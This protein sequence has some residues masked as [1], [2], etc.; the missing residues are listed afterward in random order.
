MTPRE[1]LEILN[2]AAGDGGIR[3]E[4]YDRAYDVLLGAVSEEGIILRFPDVPQVRVVLEY[5]AAQAE[6]E[7]EYWEYERD[8]AKDAERA[9]YAQAVR[10]AYD[11]FW[12][13][14][15]KK[16]HPETL[17]AA[18]QSINTVVDVLRGAKKS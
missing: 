2:S 1:A 16:I 6:E 9:A 12:E 14:V 18:Q 10:D 7:T 3:D 11:A 17:E 13:E 15:T 8:D 5:M 4:L